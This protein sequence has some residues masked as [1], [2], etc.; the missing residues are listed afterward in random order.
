[1]LNKCLAFLASH[2]LTKTFRGA[3]FLVVNSENT[4][5]PLPKQ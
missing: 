5:G 1:L 2:A 4:K 3:K